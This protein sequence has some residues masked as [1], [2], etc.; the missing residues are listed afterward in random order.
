MIVISIELWQMARSMS[1]N[2][3]IRLA[4]LALAQ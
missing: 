3:V 2:Y 1:A 4:T